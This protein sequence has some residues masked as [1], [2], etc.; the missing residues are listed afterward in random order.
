MVYFVPFL[1]ALFVMDR[2]ETREARN[3]PIRKNKQTIRILK[4][5][6]GSGFVLYFSSSFLFNEVKR[7]RERNEE[8]KEK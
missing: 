1:L 7:K 8:R 3:K 6:F 5:D 2:S 4:V